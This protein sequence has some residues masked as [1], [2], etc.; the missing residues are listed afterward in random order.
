MLQVPGDLCA[1]NGLAAV[2]GKIAMSI[3][4]VFIAMGAA[5]AVTERPVKALALDTT[6]EP[7]W[8]SVPIRID[9]ARQT[10]E[11]VEAREGQGQEQY[12]IKFRPGAKFKVIDGATFEVKGSRITLAGA[13]PLSRT[14][15][16]NSGQKRMACGTRAFVTMSK[17]LTGKFIDCR[18]VGGN[19]FECR[20]NGKDLSGILARAQG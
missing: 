4:L 8:T 1:M 18:S 5:S 12:P 3:G 17:A 7:V 10:Y 20:S 15:I 2:S 14:Q 11:R 16:C 9:P 6:S 13:T 19:L